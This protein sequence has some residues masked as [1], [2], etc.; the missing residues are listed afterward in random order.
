M[1]IHINVNLRN[2]LDGGDG[3]IKKLLNWGNKRR[4]KE[5]DHVRLYNLDNENFKAFMV[6]R[7]Y[8]IL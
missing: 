8:S 1:E 6:A 7:L 4:G 2:F 3:K 5:I